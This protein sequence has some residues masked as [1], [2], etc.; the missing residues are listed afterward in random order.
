MSNPA[1]ALAELLDDWH[2]ASNTKPEVSRFDGDPDGAVFWD[3]HRVVARYLSEIEDAISAMEEA[4]EE[5][6]FYRETLPSWSSAVFSYKVPWQTTQPA[7]RYS[8]PPG[9][10]R[11]LRALAAHL[12]A[13]GWV[14][15]LDTPHLESLLEAL[16]RA[17]VLVAEDRALTADVK[18]Y[19]L[20]LIREAEA[21][22]EDSSINGDTVYIRRLSMEL[23]GAMMTVAEM[24]AED[25]PRRKDWA[26]QARN[27]LRSVTDKMMQKAI[28]SGVDQAVAAMGQVL[29]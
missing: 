6:S 24:K 25:D 4:G 2:V 9:D 21:C 5:V 28:E 12:D 7:M 27:V 22:F 29:S 26:E 8:C 20:G 19:I 18:R 11:L 14:P 13:I 16:Q 23:G 3:G 10:I 15:K 1:L 17:R